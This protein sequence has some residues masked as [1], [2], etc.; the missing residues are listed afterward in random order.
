MKQDINDYQ[1][2]LKKHAYQP[3]EIVRISFNP[4]YDDAADLIFDNKDN[5]FHVDKNKILN[6]RSFRRETDKTQAFFR[7][8]N[9]H[10]RTRSSHTNEVVAIATTISRFLGLNTDLVEASAYGHDIGHGPMGHLFEKVLQ[11]LGVDF[12]H[13]RFSAIV[14]T[15]IEREGDGLNLTKETLMGILE[16]SS[17]AG[18]SN[19]R[20]D[21]PNENRVLMYSDKLAG[22]FSDVNDFQR[23][24]LL[25]DKDSRQIEALFPGNQRNRVNEC[26]FA[27]IKESSQKGYVSFEDSD[28]A[29][30]FK[31]LKQLMYTTKYSEISTT[32]RSD[33]LKIAYDAIANLSELK[34]CDPTIVTALM[35]NK[36]VYALD[37]IAEFEKIKLDDLKDFG[38]YESIIDGSL[39]GKK[40]SDLDLQ[41]HQILG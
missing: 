40:Y 5:Q 25:S 2:C 18:N 19:V 1:D 35:T 33:M 20:P 41:L 17:G 29:Q 26:I 34:D 23:Y 8:N 38:V 21:S 13:E 9:P 16:H 3:K 28:V 12:H 11:S 27:L 22:M 30:K 15:S 31:E 4:K 37:A 36:E 14:A 32:R 10:V 6:S 24:K 39:S 7:L